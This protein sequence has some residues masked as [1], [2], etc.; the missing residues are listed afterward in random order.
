MGKKLTWEKMSEE[1]ATAVTV[2]H[3]ESVLTTTST[4]GETKKKQ[5]KRSKAKKLACPKPRKVT[6]P[7]TK[8][9]TSKKLAGSKKVAKAKDAVPVKLV[10]DSLR[11]LLENSS[12]SKPNGKGK[13]AS[14]AGS[15]KEKKAKKTKG[16]K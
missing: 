15:K 1:T 3:N 2:S 12:P 9:G 7:A 6:L 5:K 4:S 13:V 8:D 16:S 10:A 11:Y 14:A